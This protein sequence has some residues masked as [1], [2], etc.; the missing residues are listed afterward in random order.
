MHFEILTKEQ[1]ELLKLIEK[2]NADY[3]LVGGT[4][5]AY[6]LGHRESI[7]FDLFTNS[8]INDKSIYSKIR[9]SGIQKFDKLYEAFD[10][11]HLK[12]NK[13]KVTFFEFPFRI[14]SRRKFNGVITIPSLLDL[15]AMK[16]FAFGGR[17]KWKDYVDMYFLLKERFTLEEII[18]R[19]EKLFNGEFNG[20]L[21]CMQLGYFDDINFDEKVV[22]RRDFPDD[23]E[24]KEFLISKAVKAI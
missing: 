17:G 19:A 24:I 3:Y 18:L 6:Y 20:K 1:V 22:F 13:V 11:I 7:D 21:F 12:I 23:A 8:K 16:A 2:F 4:A 14:P 5:I 9:K 15:T 10:Q